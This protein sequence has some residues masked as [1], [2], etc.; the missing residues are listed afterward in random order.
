MYGIIKLGAI[1]CLDEEELC[2][3]MNVYSQ[4]TLLVYTEKFNDEG[5][6]YEGEMD[7]AK[8]SKFAT[9]KM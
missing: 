2:E 6:K 3:E 8:I 5:E 7:A 4:P 1:N 9:S